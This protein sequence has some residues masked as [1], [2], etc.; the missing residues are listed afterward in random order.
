MANLAKDEVDPLTR[1]RL[2]NHASPATIAHYDHALPGELRAA[3][4]A[5]RRALLRY[6]GGPANPPPRVTPA[7][8]ARVL[9]ALG[10]IPPDRLEAA[11]EALERLAGPVHCSIESG[12][13]ALNAADENANA[14]AGE[15]DLSS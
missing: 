3:R 2:L 11:L 9:A 14:G 10:Q 4:Q 6:L 8:L 1:S 7:A 5:Q 15:G 12:P 13:G